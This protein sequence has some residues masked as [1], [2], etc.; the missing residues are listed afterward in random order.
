MTAE[1]STDEGYP[2]VCVVTHTIGATA[3]A[4]E[5]LLEILAAITSVTLVTAGIDPESSIRERHEV[6]DFARRGADAGI[7][8]AAVRFV[9]NQLRMCAV[10]ARRDKDVVLFFGATSYL[11]PILFARLSGH[12]VVL[13]PRGDVPLSL[14]LQWERRVPSVVARVLAGSVRLLERLGYRSAHAIV[15]YTPSMARELGLERYE[16][17]LHTDGAR[18]V[19]TERFSPRVPFADRNRRV[20]FLGRLDVEKGVPELA[21]LA[22]RLAPDTEFVFAG[23]G[24]DR[25]WLADELAA[26]IDAGSVELT[27]WIDHDEVPSVLS[28]LQLL[29]LPSA[30]TEGLPTVIL[31]AMACGTPAYASPVSGVPDVVGDGETGFLMHERGSEARAERIGAILDREDLAAIAEN[32]RTQVEEEYDFDAAVERYRSVLA[33]L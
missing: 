15:T 8:V 26:E 25:E 11:L 7:V 12:T 17:K 18:Y 9:A 27:G 19:D 4:T 24:P 31:E 22:R 10:L 14:R 28:E 5:G 13:Q 30:P 1:A 6:V 2:S 3:T 16:G 20:G 21:A 23:D 29:V 32:A 33:A